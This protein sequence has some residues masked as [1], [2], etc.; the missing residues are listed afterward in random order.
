[1]KTLLTTF[2]LSAAL[3]LTLVSCTPGPV[4]TPNATSTGALDTYNYRAE[5]LELMRIINGYRLS[6]GLLPLQPIDYLS[7]KSQEHNNYM[8]RN[9]VVNHDNFEQRAEAIKRVLAARTV[10]ENI[11]F[12]FSTPQAVLNAWLQSTGHR[13][14]L[15]GDYTHFGLSV[16]ADASGKKYYTNI[17]IK[18]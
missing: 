15:E 18:K 3:T 5:E 1:M 8:I 6:G 7:V 9:N 4:D 2:L 13:Q 14:N 10:G 12:N 16:T 17:F 11:A